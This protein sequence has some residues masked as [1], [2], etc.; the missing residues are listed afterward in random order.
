MTWV[1]SVGLPLD[2]P[3]C[4]L[5]EMVILNDEQHL[6]FFA[7]V[8]SGVKEPLLGFNLPATGVIIV[9]LEPYLRESEGCWS[10]AIFSAWEATDGLTYHLPGEIRLA[11]NDECLQTRHDGKGIDSFIERLSELAN[12]AGA[13][14][15]RWTP[16]E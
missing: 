14:W 10:V 15:P 9:D 7:M 12:I 5:L 2:A 3:P 13:G 4:Y 11:F 1:T 8:D 6:R 16:T